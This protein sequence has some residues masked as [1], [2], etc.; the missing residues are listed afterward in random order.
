M[1]TVTLSTKGQLTLNRSL[2]EHLGIKG[3][4]KLNLSKTADGGLKIL[5]EKNRGSVMDFAGCIK[6]DIHL[7]DDEIEQ[8][9]ADSYAAA[10][11]QGLEE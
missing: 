10:G 9:I 3:G 11:M 6:T 7:T 2:M 5:P 8:C 4:E 1:N